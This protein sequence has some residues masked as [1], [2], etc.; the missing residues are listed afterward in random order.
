MIVQD[1]GN[2]TSATELG[3]L[4]SVSSNTVTGTTINTIGRDTALSQ[5]NDG[6]GI[7]LATT[8]NDFTVTGTTGTYSFNL[9]AAKTIG[10]II[11]QINNATAGNV[12]AGI[13]SDG[14]GLKL[15]DAN[16]GT[17]TV[18][19][20]TDSK[21]AADLG[22]LGSA[23][24]TLS[25]GA[26]I[27]PLGT[28]LVSSLKG[29]AGLSLGTI[30]VLN[31]LGTSSSID[32]SGAKTVADIL[33]TIN[34]AN[35]GIK[36]SI[37]QS[38]SGLQI[39]DTSGG[40]NQL[41]IFNVSGTSS[42]DLGI[43]GTFESTTPIV[44]GGNLHRQYISGNTLLRDINGGKGV[45]PG[46]FTVT[47]SDGN[48]SDI[49][50]T[51]G[52][53]VTVGDILTAIN[54]RSLGVT[55]SINSNGNGIQLID[56]K[57][58]GAQLKVENKTG[59]SATDLNILGTAT[60][61]KIDGA[62]E[63]TIVVDANDTLNTVATKINTLGFAVTAA[64]INDGSDGTPYRLSLNSQNTGLAGRF[65]FNAGTTKLATQNLVQAQSAAVFIGGS[66]S[67]R[68]L[69]VTSN[70]NQI[71]NVIKGVTVNL[72]NTSKTPV[73]LSVTR[74]ST[75]ITKQL[76]SFTDGFNAISIKLKELTAYDKDTNKAGLLLGDGTA[77]TIERELYNLVN[78]VVKN[79]GRYSSFSSLGIRIGDN[80]Q[81][82]FDSAKFNSVFATDSSAVQSLFTLTK[83]GLGAQIT[84]SV[85]K[86]TDPVN[87]A[88]TV[89]T[90]AIDTQ[91]LQ[92]QDRVKQ[93]NDLL[94]A[95][96]TRL[97]KQFAN[98]ESV[99]SGLQSQQAALGSLSS[100]SSINSSNRNSS[101]SGG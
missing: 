16:G 12:S 76:Q 61:Q 41:K 82:V 35:A 95:K 75:G 59:T 81:L 2:G 98:M 1:I 52:N 13:N 92:F 90:K 20:L 93:L 7:R 33:D 73:T 74:D 78:G 40:T 26:I 34:S 24:G 32:L 48:S 21:A 63:K 31:R 65:V 23:S 9:G 85:T 72:T 5:I 45:A 54:S 55:A 6:R 87:G 86:L 50:L 22:I 11:D 66:N 89:E 69:L 14:N 80:A 97:Q 36:A 37:N 49:D 4:G 67:V 46:K 19:A 64:V 83:T 77:Q 99:L 42:D 96:K 30:G 47:A 71:T 100:L 68:P 79:A 18:A 17:V 53:Y 101:S 88:I 15:T 39:V 8:G 38:G 28:V 25:G 57:G 56:T 62:F 44:D 84:T 43:R 3:I 29:G 10:Q 60:A 70:S 91:N 27:A 94:S 58:G 51:T